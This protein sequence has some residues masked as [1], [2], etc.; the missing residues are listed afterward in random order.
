[1]IVATLKAGGLWEH[2][3]GDLKVKDDINNAK[4]EQKAMAILYSAMTDE[5]IN[6]TRNCSNAMELWAKI[7]QN[8]ESTAEK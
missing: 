3:T 6:A 2:Y 5:Q 4:K 7:K 1:L 8:N